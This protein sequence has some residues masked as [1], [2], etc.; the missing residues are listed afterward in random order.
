MLKDIKIEKDENTAY[1]EVIRDIYNIDYEFIK[2][3]KILKLFE[4]KC[5]QLM[6]LL[7]DDDN[8]Y[9]D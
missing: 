1:D 4:E 7:N 3:K 6:R 2:D 9:K 5:A 8:E